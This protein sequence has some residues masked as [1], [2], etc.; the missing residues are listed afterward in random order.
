MDES[1]FRLP[2]TNPD[3]GWARSYAPLCPSPLDL[4]APPPVVNRPIPTVELRTQHLTSH[5]T[6]RARESRAGLS[7]LLSGALGAADPDG[8]V[9]E[10]GPCPYCGAVHGCTAAVRQGG[11]VAPVHFASVRRGDRAVHALAETPVGLGLV[12][13]DGR[14]GEALRAARKPARLEAAAGAVPRGPCVEP[15]TAGVPRAVRYV[16]APWQ[17]GWVVSVVRQEHG[18]P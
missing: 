4:M 14:D 17:P 6:G 18:C 13:T 8:V 12:V 2:P 3:G 1:G 10:D 5:R 7:L 9:I 11:L 15:R 16:D